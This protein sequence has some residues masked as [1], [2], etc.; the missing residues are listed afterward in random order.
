MLEAACMCTTHAEHKI[1]SDVTDLGK[2]AA[3]ALTSYLKPS[4][5]GHVRESV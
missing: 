5:H 2:A 1:V 3:D 4:Q